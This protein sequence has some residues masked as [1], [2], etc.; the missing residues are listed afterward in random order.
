MCLV[1]DMFAEEFSCRYVVEAVVFDKVFTLGAF[2]AS[3]R[4]EDDDI[5]AFVL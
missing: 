2:A 3:G 4:T 5:H 1:S